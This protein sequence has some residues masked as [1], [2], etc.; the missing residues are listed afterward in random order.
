MKNLSVI[1][2]L[3]VL[4]GCN[5]QKEVEEKKVEL[6]E[7]KKVELAEQEEVELAEQE[8]VEFTEIS[9]ATLI[10]DVV[11]GGLFYEEKHIKIRA[12]VKEIRTISMKLETHRPN[13]IFHV[14]PNG[15]PKD[16]EELSKMS[17]EWAKK[18]KVGESYTFKL[19]VLQINYAINLDLHQI[20]TFLFE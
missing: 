7:E 19:H 11:N 4:F 3:C 2:L 5:T 18:Y 13:V 1:L 6:S 16:A 17:E 14:S 10:N 15:F 20:H 8:E 12:K 9:L